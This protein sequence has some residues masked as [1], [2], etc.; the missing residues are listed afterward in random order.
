MLYEVITKAV[1]FGAKLSVSLTGEGFARVDALRW[2][3][4]HEGQDLI[5]QVEAYRARYGYYPERVLADPI[6]GTRSNR[7][8]L[9]ERGIH[10]AGKPLGVITSYSIH[11]TKLYEEN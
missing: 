9:K 11:Y 4:F 7:T 8:Y 3:A 6:Y 10:F 2:E 1:E 5:A